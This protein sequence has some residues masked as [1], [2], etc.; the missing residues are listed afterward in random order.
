MDRWDA[1]GAVGVALIAAG[2]WFVWP[3]G[4]LFWLGLVCLA[5]AVL[6]AR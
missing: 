6:G 1:I 3:V 5:G 2:I 4:V